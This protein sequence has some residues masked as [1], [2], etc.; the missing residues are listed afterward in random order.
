MLEELIDRFGEPPKS[1]LSLLRV[2]RL[3]ALAHAVYITEIK[4]TGSLIKLTMF[5]RA[6]IN[7]EK[8]PMLVAQ[9]KSS[10][11]FNMAENPYFT[12]DLKMAAW[13]RSDVLDVVEELI[14]QMRK[15]LITA[16]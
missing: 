11:K 8:I 9:Y 4:Q 2:A 14:S 12:F 3:K 5:E 16:E 13:Q 1:V 6:R 7:P 15:E 10:L